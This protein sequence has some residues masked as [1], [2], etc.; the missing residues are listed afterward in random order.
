MLEAKLVDFMGVQ[1]VFDKDTFTRQPMAVHYS[2]FLCNRI[3]RNR[4][5]DSHSAADSPRTPFL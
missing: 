5:S 1:E 2:R 3:E 4:P